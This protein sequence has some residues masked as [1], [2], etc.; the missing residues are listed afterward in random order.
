MTTIPTKYGIDTPSQAKITVITGLP[1]SGKTYLIQRKIIP[2]CRKPVLIVDPNKEYLPRQKDGVH[3][4]RLESYDNA[5]YEIEEIIR[6]ISEGELHVKTLIVDES[7]VVFSKL[8]LLPNTKRL[9]NTLRHHDIDLFVVARRPTDINITM[10]ELARDRYVF[11]T[12]GVNDI[13]RLNE[14][15]QGLGYDAA[16]LKKWYFLRVFDDSPVYGAG[17]VGEKSKK[18][19]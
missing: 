18:P 1:G 6:R 16:T 5:E 9:V 10:S 7:N 12:A 19:Q 8:N 2:E 15:V 4:Y 3:V 17:K 13:K 11:R 14:I